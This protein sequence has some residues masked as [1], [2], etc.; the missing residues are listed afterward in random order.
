MKLRIIK[1]RPV[2]AP[3]GS[4]QDKNRILM[5]PLLSLF[6]I[7]EHLLI[8]GVNLIFRIYICLMM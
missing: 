8:N 6:L 2:F 3:G 5:Y 1:N 7:M 4:V